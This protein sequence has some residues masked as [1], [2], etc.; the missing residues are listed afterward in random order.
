MDIAERK[1]IEINNLPLEIFR[2]DPHNTPNELSW[3]ADVFM[4]LK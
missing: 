2:D 4:P 3:Q 1:N